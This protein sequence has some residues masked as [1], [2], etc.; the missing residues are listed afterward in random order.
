MS[1]RKILPLF[2]VGAIAIAGILGVAA[3]QPVAAQATTPTPSAP[4]TQANPANPAAPLKDWGGKGGMRGGYSEQ[5][6]ATALGIDLTTLQAA[7]KS[8]QAE[9]LKQAV[10]AG[11]ITQAQADEITA[12]GGHFGDFGHFG[13]SG[14]DY[15]ALLAKALG[16]STDQLQAGFVKAYNTA[17][18][19]AVTNGNMTQ[20]QADLAKGR[21]ALE[22][23]SKYQ[24]SMQSA[25]QVAVQQAVTDGVITQAQADQLLKNAPRMGVG[26]PG[27]GGPSFGGHGGRGGGMRG[28]RPDGTQPTTP[29]NPSTTPATPSSGL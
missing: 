28:A 29:A 1:F 6:L 4:A 17:I 14:I 27:L 24:S 18:D 9:A 15:N 22:N 20:D 21:F 12:R 13:A 7:E 23:N 8:A 16:I 2:V 11:L 25:Y 19:N 10:T 3:Y 26:G 5:D